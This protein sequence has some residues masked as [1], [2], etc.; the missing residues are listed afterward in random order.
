MCSATTPI[1]T[2][3]VLCVDVQFV[4]QKKIRTFE[5]VFKKNVL[6]WH[7]RKSLHLYIILLLDLIQP[8]LSCILTIPSCKILIFAVRQN[9][10]HKLL[11]VRG[12]R[13]LLFSLHPKP[14]WVAE[15]IATAESSNL[16]VG[17]S[18]Y[19]DEITED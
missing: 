7:L 15:L 8:I 12:S 11:L 9:T 18:C 3:C 16:A 5:F 4:N 17:S 14:I 10:L 13:Y 6:I 1:R 2:L 19:I